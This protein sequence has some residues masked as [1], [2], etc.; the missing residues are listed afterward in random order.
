MIHPAHTIPFDELYH[1]L[2]LATEAGLVN[3]QRHENGL[4]LFCYSRECTYDRQWN[5]TTTVARG[6]IVDPVSRHLVA[7]PFPKF[8]NVGEGDTTIPELPFETFEKLDGSLIIAFHHDGEW[9][10]AT[11]GSFYSD[12]AKWAAGWLKERGTDALLPGTT[13]LFEAI[14]PENRI[15]IHYDESALVVLGAY[16]VDGHE[17][18]AAAL[19]EIA[20]ALG[21][22]MAKR[23]AYDS[24]AD[25]LV[26][27]KGLPPSEEGFVIR[28]ENGFRLKVKGDEYRRIH[29][30]VSRLTPLAMWE[31]MEAGDN[32]DL[33][34][35]DLPEEFWAD[36]DQIT[37]ILNSAIQKVMAETREV[38]K[39][40]ASWSDKQIGLG[41]A[42]IPEPARHFLFSYRKNGGDLLSGRSRKALFR[43]IRPTGNKLPN[44]VPSYAVN[45]VM[46]E[47]L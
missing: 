27:A 40:T 24:V 22:R 32:L 14:Y 31:A 17:Y 5:E 37:T 25:L 46:E 12:Q 6:L 19:H 35:R 45:L 8:F 10:F 4:E 41:L 18:S 43:H 16:T 33:I 7:T 38:A 26:T 21:T 1:C 29:A 28:F 39:Q 11:K 2:M 44:Y 47:S 30:L 34:R 9:H 3:R 23:Y 13:Y 15:V 42:N 20:A 36:F